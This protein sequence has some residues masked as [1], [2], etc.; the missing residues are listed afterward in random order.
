MNDGPSV[1]NV[2]NLFRKACFWLCSL[3]YRKP[4]AA[5]AKKGLLSAAEFELAKKEEIV[6]SLLVKTRT[7]SNEEEDDVKD[8]S[9]KKLNN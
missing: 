6:S 2:T 4:G 7:D 5:Q 9:K 1:T 3:N 8:N